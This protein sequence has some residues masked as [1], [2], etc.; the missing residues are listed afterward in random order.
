MKS[1]SQARSRETVAALGAAEGAAAVCC[2]CAASRVAPRLFRRDLQRVSRRC[3]LVQRSSPA[4]TCAIPFPKV[5]RKPHRCHVALS[6]AGEVLSYGWERLGMHR[7]PRESSQQMLGS[8]LG[9]AFKSILVE[10][11]AD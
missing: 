4:E 3:V 11:L 10:A 1:G 2:A 6:E 7:V 9:F 5:F 8:S